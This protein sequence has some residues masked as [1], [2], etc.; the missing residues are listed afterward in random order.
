LAATACSEGLSPTKAVRE[1]S[2]P[3]GI[4]DTMMAKA[5]A[6]SMTRKAP[7]LCLPKENGRMPRDTRPPDYVS[8]N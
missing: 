1:K 4:M 5:I 8:R 3:T 6:A 2:L 7:I